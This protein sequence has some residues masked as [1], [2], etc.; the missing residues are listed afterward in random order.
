LASD[1]LA[2]RWWDLIRSVA[3]VEACGMGIIPPN[4]AKIRRRKSE[5]TVNLLTLHT[6]C[7]ELTTTAPFFWE[8]DKAENN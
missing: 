1:E 6:I 5:T 8:K 3:W 7:E 2:A 4:G